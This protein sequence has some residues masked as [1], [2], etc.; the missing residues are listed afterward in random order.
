MSSRGRM[1][2]WCPL[3]WPD[4]VKDLSSDLRY[5]IICD[6]GNKCSY[7]TK[8]RYVNGWLCELSTQMQWRQELRIKSRYWCCIVLKMQCRSLPRPI[9]FA[10]ITYIARL[11]SQV[12]SLFCLFYFRH[13]FNV[14]FHNLLGLISSFA[15]YIDIYYSLFY[16]PLPWFGHWG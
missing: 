2:V 11:E 13:L 15:R 4:L 7:V 16:V 9:I 6:P 10:Q 8:Q 1:R 3:L 14:A 5:T 12:Q